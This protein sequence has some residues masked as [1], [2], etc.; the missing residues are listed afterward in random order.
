MPPSRSLTLAIES[1]PIAG[2]FTISRGTKTAAEVLVATL[3]ED[4][5]RGRGECVPYPRNGETPQG[6]LDLLETLRTPI[7]SGMTRAGLQ[8]A[9]PAGAARNA[10]DCALIDLECKRTG[11]RAFELLGLAPPYPC[12]TAYTISLGT[13]EKMAEAAA[14]A[15]HRPV[16]K[17]KLGGE[18]D[19]ARI[20]AVRAAAPDADLIVDANE[21]W[22]PALFGRLAGAC[23][24]A[25]VRLIEQPFPAAGDAPLRAIESPIPLCADESFHD[26]RSLAE[27]EGKYQ[28]V[29]IK[30]DKTGGL[31]EA[32]ALAE[33]ARERGLGLMVGCMVGTSLAM[34]PAML[35]T[36]GAGFVDLDGPLLLAQDRQP[37]LVF[38]G[39][40]VHPPGADLW[41]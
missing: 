4:G 24:E 39:A 3:E 17:V 28:F 40:S 35:L 9:L 26:R 41:G 20:A 29:N 30:L 31:T 10:L 38:E 27:I 25:R 6:V 19:E 12:V 22:T 15:A 5:A 34:A 11:R 36:A 13:P 8:A 7:E 37:G 21:A 23:A 33:D 32:L 18:G 16:L 14:R 2:G 1:W